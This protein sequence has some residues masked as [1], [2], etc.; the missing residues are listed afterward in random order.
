[1]VKIADTQ[2]IST[3][4]AWG[5]VAMLFEKMV[6]NFEESISSIED[7][8]YIKVR[9]LNNHSRAIL[10]E[11]MVQFNGEDDI[12]TDIRELNLYINKL[13][14]EGEL[15]GRVSTYRTCIKVLVPLI[16]AFREL[17]L[18]EKPSAVTGLTY[19]RDSLDEYV[20]KENR[21]FKG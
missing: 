19:G 2:N 13:M 21:D 5:L 16:I 3:T 10:T 4:N 18:D 15:E 17:E 9:E 7:D 14:T 11:L 20:L 8:D 1:M 12:S 6:E